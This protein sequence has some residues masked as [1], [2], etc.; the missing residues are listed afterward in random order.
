[1]LCMCNL[2]FSDLALIFDIGLLLF[3]RRADS[4]SEDSGSED[5]DAEDSDAED[6]DAEDSEGRP[7]I[8]MRSS[9]FRIHRSASGTCS[10]KTFTRHL[11]KQVAFSFMPFFLHRFMQCSRGSSSYNT[12]ARHRSL[13]SWD[14]P[15]Q[16]VLNQFLR[17]VHLQTLVTCSL[18][19]YPQAFEP[20]E[21]S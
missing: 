9:L 2:T 5:S 21:H 6:S 13:V 8:Q 16:H 15:R 11:V 18:G 1:M 17:Q 14:L 10:N 12:N 20:R 7:R 19:V 4:D 3:H